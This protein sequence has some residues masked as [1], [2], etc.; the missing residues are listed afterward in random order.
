MM[1][2]L[3]L[4]LIERI[5]L[6]YLD[7]SLLQMA[8]DAEKELEIKLKEAYELGKEKGYELGYYNGAG[9]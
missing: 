9:I 4:E 7:E 6:H 3:T 1:P 2:K 8:L 5:K